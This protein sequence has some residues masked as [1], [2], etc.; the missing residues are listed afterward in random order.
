[1]ANTFICP[2]C[3]KETQQAI[4]GN[5]RLCTDCSRRKNAENTKRWYQEQKAKN[6]D[7]WPVKPPKPKTVELTDEQKAHDA[8]IDARSRKQ[9][10]LQC[11][12][13][14]YRAH[15]AANNITNGCDHVS[16]TGKLRNRGTGK[17]G[18]CGSFVPLETETKADRMARRRRALRISEADKAQNTGL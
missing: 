11:R 18:E 16:H 7:K 10:Q 9:I 6:G 12:F 17:P 13:C 15:D 1:M 5:K 3:G 2:G 4:T 8:E 14:K